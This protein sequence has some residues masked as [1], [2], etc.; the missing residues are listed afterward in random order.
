M[1]SQTSTASAGN[2][3]RILIVDDH[4]VIRAG[5]TTLLEPHWNICG[6]ASNGDDAVTQ[7][8]TLKPDLVI[9]DIS[10][11]GR[12]GA[13]V[14]RATRHRLPKTRIIFYSIHESATIAELARLL[15][16]DGFVTKRQ[17][18]ADL[19]DT[20]KRVLKVSSPVP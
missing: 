3:V 9:L 15:D 12:G 16:V 17:P 11:P 18:T 1:V 4:E 6:E 5:L 10:L 14:A 8:E 19:V 13:S 7:I 2:T 20:I